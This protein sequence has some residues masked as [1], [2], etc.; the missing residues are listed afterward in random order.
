MLPLK[1]R[2]RRAILLIT[3]LLFSVLT[4]M[5]VGAALEL[6]PSSL[7][8][9]GTDQGL[10]LASRA[11]QSGVDW[12]RSRISQD[13]NWRAE[14]VQTL[15]G[16]GLVVREGAGQ[17]VG[18]IQ[19]GSG[20]S[21]FR[22]R[23]NY[24]DGAASASPDSDSLNDPPVAWTDMPY[25][26]CNNLLGPNNRPIPLASN[27]GASSS[28]GPW[29]N[30]QLTIPGSTML[31]SV[32]GSYGRGVVTS[33]GLPTAYSGG[34]QRKT[35][36]AILRLGNNQPV[37]AAA[38][39]AAGNLVISA[40]S[41]V[42]L[43]ASSGQV[44]RLR[45]KADLNLSGGVAASQAEL[46]YGTGQTVSGAVSAGVS[47]SADDSTG[48]FKIPSSK[49][50]TPSS[51]ANFPAG[52]YVVTDS[53]QVQYFNMNYADFAT[54]SPVPTGTLVT[55][56]SGVT[57]VGPN[58][59][60]APKYTLRV[61]SDVAVTPS[62]AVTDFALI[63]DGGAPQSASYGGVPAASGTPSPS[64]SPALSTSYMLGEYFN[65]ASY[66]AK[67]KLT[68]GT[69]LAWQTIVGSQLTPTSTSA[70]GSSL[71]AGSFPTNDVTYSRY[72]IG[73]G[74][75]WIPNGVPSTGADIYVWKTAPLSSVTSLFDNANPADYAAM[76][77]ATQSSLTPPSPTSS[78]SPASGLGGTLKPKDLELELQG[79]A[80]GLVF[81]NDGNITIGAQIQGN[82][83][84]LISKKDIAL[85]GTSTELSSTPGAQLGLNLYAE[86][87]ITIDAYNLQSTGGTFHGVDLKGIV[88]AWKNVAV[89]ASDGTS[90]APFRLRGSMVAYGGDPSA[91]PTPG[92][93][94]ARVQAGTVDIT[95][96]PSYLASLMQ[97]GPFSLEVLS[98]HEF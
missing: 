59:A 78:P 9:T 82:G 43:Q 41:P 92:L 96:D 45:T 74:N 55:L 56:P 27:G 47:V 97:G 68:P 51:P 95:Y 15:Q 30:T 12:A 89:L 4:L 11:S 65:S 5:F 25:V 46:R 62:G 84:A 72:S 76:Q 28:S 60:P 83:S 14:N 6:A 61:T 57:L 77:T 88:Y 3:V 37:T 22:I 32:E 87:N 33:S 31:L 66:S 70:T 50:R 98:W 80:S 93:A 69:L 71:G 2:G 38:I 90:F 40:Q 53:G 7:A 19:Q 21:R 34:F 20:W 1:R 44:A 10:S 39:M 91:D 79:G 54:A 16:P 26:S 52:T 29:G 58:T 17:A 75:L 36:Q 42:Q 81:A 49:V 13:P 24:Q 85:I 8:R 23:F 67:L 64:P 18:W 86:G 94:E 63:P 35:I 48:F 73:G